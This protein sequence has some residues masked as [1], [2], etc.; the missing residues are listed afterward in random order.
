MDAALSDR[1]R[2]S[3]QDRE[4][5]AAVRRERARLLAFIRSR[6]L[7]AAEAEDRLQEAFYDLVAA[8]RLMQPVEQ[9]RAWLMRVALNRIIERRRRGGPG[10]RADPPVAAQD[11]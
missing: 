1:L 4:I 3:A 2:T 11:A 8:Y 10:L 7:D 5:S 6:V 9:G